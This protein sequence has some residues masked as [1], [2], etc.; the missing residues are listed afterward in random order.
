MPGGANGK[1]PAGQCRRHKRWGFSPWVG[2]IPW[3]R[4][5]QHTPAWEGGVQAVGLQ[6]LTPLKE[7][8]T[9]HLS[10]TKPVDEVML[11][12]FIMAMMTVSFCQG[13]RFEEDKQSPKC[14]WSSVFCQK[15][16]PRGDS[17]SKFM[18]KVCLHHRLS[19]PLSSSSPQSL[20][21][22]LHDIT[23]NCLYLH[24]LFS[25]PLHIDY[26]I[27]L[28]VWKGWKKNGEESLPP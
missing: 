3:R 22:E 21:S 15:R 27:L 19:P 11:Y 2:K 8:S 7:L 16:T 1:E 10:K 14:T 12:L 6:S 26:K 18:L 25:I 20:L 9:Q 23:S 17:F 28:L 13:Q 4:T 24:W 5:W